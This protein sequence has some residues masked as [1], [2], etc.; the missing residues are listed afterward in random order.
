MKHT[1]NRKQAT[2]NKAIASLKTFFAY[3]ADN[4]VV[5]DNPMT[6]IKI[7]KV[8]SYDKVGEKGISKWLTKEEQDRYIDYVDLEKNEF[9][10]LRNLAIIDCMLFGG[11]RVA[12]VADLKI[13]DVKINGDIT[14][15]I[16]EGKKGRYATVTLNNKHSR[17][18]RNWLRMLEGLTEDKNILH[19][20]PCLSLSV[21]ESLQQEG[22]K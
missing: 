4:G 8:E 1:L 20:L 15:T 5:K 3:L 19:Q 11:L 12:E 22:Y 17:N 2:I 13:T 16:R 6:R 10:R 14:L 7:Q 18:V 9:K 21:L